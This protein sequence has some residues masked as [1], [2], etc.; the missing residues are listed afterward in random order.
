MTPTN[1]VQ[2]CLEMSSASHFN[3]GYGGKREMAEMICIIVYYGNRQDGSRAEYFG[4]TATFDIPPPLKT[5]GDL[6]NIS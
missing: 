4:I 6:K 1:A 3:G 2:L 5:S